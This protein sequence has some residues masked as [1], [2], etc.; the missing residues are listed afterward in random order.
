MTSA[1]TSGAWA[2]SFTSCSAATRPSWATAA[3][4][5]AGTAARPA[6]PARCEWGPAVHPSPEHRVWPASAY[7]HTHM[8]PHPCLPSAPQGLVHAH[9]YP[10]PWRTWLV[11]PPEHP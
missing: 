3:A 5:A 7:T 1:A 2:S 8:H 4:T 11:N 10:P 9:T 6:R